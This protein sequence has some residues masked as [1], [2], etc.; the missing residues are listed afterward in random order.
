MEVRSDCSLDIVLAFHHP[1]LIEEVGLA[2][3]TVADHVRD[4]WVA[5][6]VRD[7]PFVPCRLAPR[8][9]IMQPRSRLMADGV[10]LEEYEKPRIT[11][12]SSFGGV[13][14]V[15]G[16]VPDGERSV[17]LPSVQTLG[18][19]WAICSAAYS[20][21][22]SPPSEDA[23]AGYCI[24]AESAY[25]FCPIQVADLWTQC[26]CW[27]GEEGVTGTAIDLRMGFGGAFAPNR[28]ERLST[29]VAA[30]AQHLQAAFDAEQPP[31]LASQFTATRRALQRIGQLPPGDSQ[32]HPRYLQV[33]VDDFTGVAG[34]DTVSAPAS[35]AHI[36]VADEH[37]RAAGCVPAPA[38][39]RVHVHARL[40]ILALSA[41]G[42]YAAP[43]KVAIG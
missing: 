3:R 4:E 38:S 36:Q 20:P 33:F 24:D 31:A 8:G 21:A 6:P 13:D 2:S 10:T 27:W 11:T 40:T 5:P 15:N 1:S 26:F 12:D 25:S 16:G 30:Y 32:C 41:F 22:G 28:F 43:H 42:L 34:T 17:A 37:M 35:V 39:S 9:V 19:G 7:L 23:V 14:S 18:R 29:L